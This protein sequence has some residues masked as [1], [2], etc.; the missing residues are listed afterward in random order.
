MAGGCLKEKLKDIS[1]DRRVGQLLRHVVHHLQCFFFGIASGVRER[2][3]Q[4]L[5]IVY[6]F[7]FQ[8]TLVVP[9]DQSLDK[10]QQ[11]LV[12]FLRSALATQHSLLHLLF[13]SQ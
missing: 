6:Q 4:D 3:F 5:N 8:L 7:L 2:F 13:S 12:T 10:S 1:G 9:P 11:M